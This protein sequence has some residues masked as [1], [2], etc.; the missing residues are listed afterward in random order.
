MHI[1]YV[2]PN[3]NI[4]VYT[5]CGRPTPNNTKIWGAVYQIFLPFNADF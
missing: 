1:F 5:Y 4:Q 3:I 2:A